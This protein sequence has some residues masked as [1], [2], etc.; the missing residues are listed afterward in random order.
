MTEKELYSLTEADLLQVL[1]AKRPFGAIAY[2][3][4][5]G[6]DS[7]YKWGDVVESHKKLYQLLILSGNQLEDMGYD[8]CEI[9]GNVIIENANEARREACLHYLGGEL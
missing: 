6:S 9:E 8:V 7:Y 3:S 4:P 1:Q 5:D 2:V